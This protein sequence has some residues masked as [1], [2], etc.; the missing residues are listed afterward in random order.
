M[1]RIYEGLQEHRAIAPMHLPVLRQT[2]N[3]L[4]QDVTIPSRDM[5]QTARIPYVLLGNV[6]AGY[7]SILTI[8]PGVIIKGT[9]Y[10]IT[11]RRGLIVEG[12]SRDHKS[13]G[14]W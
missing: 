3:E 13:P 2:P 11:V 9:G 12:G 4:A 6:I 14:R 10:D 5:A 8:E 7:S 1:S